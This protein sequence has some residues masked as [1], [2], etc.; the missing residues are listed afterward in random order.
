MPTEAASIDRRNLVTGHFNKGPGYKEFRP[1]G[2]HDW[3]LIYTISGQGR[4]SYS[5]GMMVVRADEVVLIAPGV[6]HGYEVDESV[7]R[8]ELMWAHFV[9]PAEWQP[10][11]RW[12]AVAD[13]LMRLSLPD[14]PNRHRVLDHLK[15]AHRIKTTYTRRREPLALH[16]LHGCLL[17]CDEQNP[18]PEQRLDDRVRVALEVLCRHLAEP[19][20][21]SDLA[22]RVGLSPSRLRHLF[23]QQVG[24]GPQQFLERQRMARAQQLLD[25]SSF[26]VA[27]ISRE[28]GFSNP[29][30]FTLRFKR[31]T[32]LSPTQYRRRR[33]PEFQDSK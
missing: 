29:F 25:R 30:Y 28:V 22:G 18:E 13:G 6:Q 32:G 20:T 12:P 10:I 21:M 16:A 17:W 2:C 31:A 4:F 33:K 11:L 1:L 26:N 5:G 3:L 9:P 14:G 19:M 15:E 27:E 24:I 8:W 23:H 7:G